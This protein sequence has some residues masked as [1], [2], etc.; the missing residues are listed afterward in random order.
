MPVGF[1]RQIFETLWQL[2]D[3]VGKALARLP[4]WPDIVRLAA[5]LVSPV[6]GAARATLSA[7][8]FLRR[9][10]WLLE[11]ESLTKRHP[12]VLALALLYVLWRG[13]RT[14]T[15]GHIGTDASIYPFMAIVSGFNPCL[16]IAC[17][18]FYGIGDLIQKFLR[19]DM[20]GVP[21]GRADVNFWPAMFGYTV[22]Y[23]SL[24]CMGVVPGVLARVARHTAR[25]VLRAVF[26]RRASAVAD[27]AGPGAPGAATAGP[28]A[29]G[30]AA[31]SFPLAEFVA[32]VVG[33][34]VGGYVTMSVLAPKLS[35]PAFMWR[36]NPDVSC[37]KLEVGTWLVGRAD[38]GAQAGG[39]GGGLVLVTPPADRPPWSL[40]H[41]P[42]VN[43]VWDEETGRWVP[44]DEAHRR[45]ME[46]EGYDFDPHTETWRRP[47]SS[48]APVD[49]GRERPGVVDYVPFSFEQPDTRRFE[50]RLNELD[51][52]E[53]RALDEYQRLSAE[54]DRAR[55]DG[56]RWLDEQLTRRLDDARRNVQTVQGEKLTLTGQASRE[57]D[58]GR[59]DRA[60]VRAAAG[61]VA[62]LP[63]QLLRSLVAPDMSAVA[64]RLQAAI[65]A[66]RRL[67]G[68][69]DAQDPLFARHDALLDEYR[70]LRADL[71]TAADPESDDRLR[72]RLDEV[73][74]RIDGLTRDMSRIHDASAQWQR[75]A[76]E[77]NAQALVTSGDLTL[78]GTS[79]VRSAQMVN[80]LIDQYRR[81][82]LPWQPGLRSSGGG[83]YDVDGLRPSSTSPSSQ[84]GLNVADG[85]AASPEAIS[86]M[87]HNRIF[88]WDR[89]TGAVT[90]LRGV[91]AIDVPA[92][93]DQM[94]IIRDPRTGRMTVIDAGDRVTGNERLRRAA[95]DAVDRYAT[96]A[97]PAPSA[98]AAPPAPA[99]A[100][101]GGSVP[102]SSEPDLGELARRKPGQPMSRV[103]RQVASAEAKRD[104]ILRGD[105]AA[106]G[107]RELPTTRSDWAAIDRATGAEL[108]PPRKNVEQIL[109]IERP[110]EVNVFAQANP[111]FRQVD[112]LV[113][114]AYK[115]SGGGFPVG[116]EPHWR[117]ERFEAYL[118]A[119]G[120]SDE[121]FNQWIDTVGQIK[122]TPP[123]PT[124]I[125]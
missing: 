85:S 5:I 2:R 106:V 91:D 119:N 111:A 31:E 15:H 71:S 96:T 66:R 115:R 97:P 26:V 36:P 24:M 77:A 38:V 99:A 8:P 32:A 122:Y 62:A 55:R 117:V 123:G 1:G 18:V 27:G 83:D 68:Q 44:A 11:V 51:H 42:S 94:R 124:R 3:A 88:R 20:F 87:L 41:R 125:R 113:R 19:P 101:G 102:P 69:L 43:H 48:V 121:A 47:P 35:V 17:G 7:F 93:A 90:E 29:S 63:G 72:E 105:E 89:R 10:E 49:P 98:G 30:A 22:S 80:R 34:G 103:E 52:A 56:D 65:D 37:L 64:E 21:K 67:Q 79:A 116:G 84:P 59:V 14:T 76:A 86:R 73:R 45:R 6:T 54:R 108:G 12:V 23:S 74:R 9:L 109:G 114:D 70:R 61:E 39:A 110:P 50:S 13:W 95:L 82:N 33:G 16:G 104:A 118:K 75:R 57:A 120:V 25:G 100:G 60:T 46:R 81:G 40:M 78:R 58:Y 112:D 4:L 28:S 53:R 107:Q 92:N